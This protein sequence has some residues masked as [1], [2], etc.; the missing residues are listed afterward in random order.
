[1]NYIKLYRGNLS[2][3]RQVNTDYSRALLMTV[4][5][6]F[7]N[8]SMPAFF[9][10]AFQDSQWKKSYNDL[11]LTVPHVGCSHFMHLNES[12][13]FRYLFVHRYLK[14]L[15]SAEKFA[16]PGEELKEKEENWY[17]FNMYAMPCL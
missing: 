14:K 4:L 9:K 13:F 8:E 15:D 3:P 5:Q 11:A 6:E 1:M 17:R 7:N 10:M 12:N 16:W 2:S